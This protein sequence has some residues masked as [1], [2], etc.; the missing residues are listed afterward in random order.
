MVWCSHLFKNLPQFVVIHTVEGFSRVNENKL[1][2][3]NVVA[4]AQ[5]CILI[6]W[7]VGVALSFR[8]PGVVFTDP[9]VIYTS[10]QNSKGGRSLPGNKGGGVIFFFSS[11]ILYFLHPNGSVHLGLSGWLPKQ[12]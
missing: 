11:M 2:N 10:K 12:V 6:Q 7:T 9:L 8:L 5:D 3:G 4:P 1:E